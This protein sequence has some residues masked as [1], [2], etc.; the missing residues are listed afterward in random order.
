MTRDV[1]LDNPVS[2]KAEDEFNRWPF[3]HRLAATISGFDA[4]QGAPVLGLFGSWG[5]G[6]STVLNFVRTVLESDHS[7]DVIVYFFNPWLFK[8]TDA[9]LLEFFAGM[10]QTVKAKLG[11]PGRKVG[12]LMEKYGG[13]LNAVP[14]V[15]KGLSDL[16]QSL[17]KELASDST[18]AKR[19]RL[20]A[21]MREQTKK[22]VVLIDDLDRLDRDEIMT[23]LKMVR[24]TANFPNVVYLLAFDEERVG[25]VAGEAYGEASDGRQFLEK[26]IQFPFALPAIGR[27]RLASYVIRHAREVCQEADIKIGGEEW[28][29]F[30]LLCRKALLIRLNTPR[31]AIR[32]ANALRFALPLLKG[33]VDPFDQLIV[34]AVRI[35]HPE[36]YAVLGSLDSFEGATPASI[37]EV[38][39]RRNP[40]LSVQEGDACA[41]ITTVLLRWKRTSPKTIT[42]TRYHGRYFSY[43]VAPDDVSDAELD[44]LLQVAGGQDQQ[45]IVDNAIATLA[46]SRPSSLVARL[47]SQVQFMN[48]WQANRLSLALAAAGNAFNDHGSF[49]ENATAN[50]TAAIIAELARLHLPSRALDQS[51]RDLEVHRVAENVLSCAVP[52]PFALRIYREMERRSLAE[53]DEAKV[54]SRRTLDHEWR[55]LRSILQAR[56]EAEAQK[57]PPYVLYPR[58]DALRQLQFW[59]SSDPDAERR[60]LDARLR[61]NPGEVADVL[62]LFQDPSVTYGFIAELATPSILAEAARAYLADPR[63]DAGPD[64]KRLRIARAFL[65]EHEKRTRAARN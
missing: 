65:E 26:I 21:A 3:S 5:S 7:D 42:D 17:G 56:I 34:E 14:L 29:E 45:R 37:M 27:E 59:Q 12:T 1:T 57:R 48:L 51:G 40:S 4:R 16:T 35:L 10:A 50:K 25:R 31:Q 30:A 23:T 43:A 18:Q 60:W 49:E 24:L 54:E 8:D 47:P 55:T 22:V 63:S 44:H 36:L 11:S 19:D 38:V 2:L 15:G 13:A 9:L 39:G 28:D 46:E 61:T 33:E 58:L 41:Q 64:D 6:K 52:T 62:G 32:Y 53:K 20:V